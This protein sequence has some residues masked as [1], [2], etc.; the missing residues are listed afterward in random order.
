MKALA[1]FAIFSISACSAQQDTPSETQ[2]RT[3]PTAQPKL[4]QTNWNVDTGT[5]K[6]TFTTSQSGAVFTSVFETFE[7]QIWFHADDL[8]QSKVIATIDMFS[9]ETGDMESTSALT[10]KDWFHAEAFPYAVF[11]TTQ[12]TQLGADTYEAAAKLTLRGVSKDIVL[13]FTLNIENGQA[14]M[15]GQITLNRAD[16]NV[17]TGMW[18]ATDSVPNE[19]RV[20]IDI[21]AAQ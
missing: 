3:P 18:S 11:E 1:I 4:A 13:P 7:T 10:E 5:S 2:A 8:A 6:L 12:F 15:Q 19:V 14:H 20:N 21:Y 17:G 16:Y 9:A